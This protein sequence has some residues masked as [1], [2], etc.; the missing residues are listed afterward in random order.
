MKFNIVHFSL[1]VYFI[2]RFFRYMVLER[3]TIIQIQ[4]PYIL[5][6]YEN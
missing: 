2:P 6:D 1:L 4:S 5:V 3:L